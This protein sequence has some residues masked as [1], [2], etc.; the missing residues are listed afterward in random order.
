MKM[1]QKV[2]EETHLQVAPS[3]RPPDRVALA[4]LIPAPKITFPHYHPQEEQFIDT[5]EERD[6]L[7]KDDRTCSTKEISRTTSQGWRP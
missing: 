3:L 1:A 4:L 2:L 6:C 7:R 5:E